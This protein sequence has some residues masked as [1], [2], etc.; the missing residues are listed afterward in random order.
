MRWNAAVGS[1]ASA[2]TAR[3]AGGSRAASR[4]GSVRTVRRFRVM[5]SPTLPSP[6]VEPLANTPPS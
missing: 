5:S 2:R 6:R 3:R 1:T 4:T